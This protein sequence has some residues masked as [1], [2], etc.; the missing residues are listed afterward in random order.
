M[1][2]VSTGSLLSSPPLALIRLYHPLTRTVI[3][4]KMR[5]TRAIV[6]EYKAHIRALK[7]GDDFERVLTGKNATQKKKGGKG[8]K[9]SAGK[10]RKS[11]GGDSGQKTKRRKSRF[12]VHVLVRLA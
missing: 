1:P 4:Q 7:R 9:V 3:G 12:V 6:L 8:G 2:K 10:K 11:T 5:D